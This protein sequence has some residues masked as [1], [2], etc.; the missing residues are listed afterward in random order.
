MQNDENN[1]YC[2]K[3]GQSN[4]LGSAYCTK[5][6]KK[7]LV[8]NE[9]QNNNIQSTPPVETINTQRN[10]SN[11]NTDDSEGN[12]LGIISLVL[13]FLGPI[14][15]NLIAYYMPSSVK[16][17]IESL[18]GFCPMVAILLMIVGRVQY[19]KNKILKIAMWVII[20]SVIFVIVS[21]ILFTIWCYIT[22]SNMDTSGCG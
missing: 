13:Y 12:I 3:C 16:Q 10:I 15:V 21:F 8:T 1:I 9:I 11:N 14:T 17:Y 20:A 19:P 2:S 18:T 4:T 7:L 22:C 6:G 5:C